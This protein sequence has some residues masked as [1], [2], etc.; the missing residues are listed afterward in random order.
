MER[1]LEEMDLKFQKNMLL[2]VLTIQQKNVI[3]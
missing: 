2:K 1:I 3:F